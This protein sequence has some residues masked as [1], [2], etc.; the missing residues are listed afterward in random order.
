MNLTPD[1]VKSG[2]LYTFPNQ[3]DVVIIEFSRTAMKILSRTNFASLLDADIEKEVS[4]SSYVYQYPV[5][6][7]RLAVVKGK[8]SK[9]ESKIIKYWAQT[10]VGGSGSPVLNENL[11]VIGIHCGTLTDEVFKNDKVQCKGIKQAIRIDEILKA[12]KDKLLDEYKGETM[13]IKENLLRRT[14]YLEWFEHSPKHLLGRSGNV[15]VYKIFIQDRTSMAAKIIERL[16]NYESQ[17]DVLSKK[18]ELVKALPGHL[19]Q[20]LLHHLVTDKQNARVLIFTE[21]FEGG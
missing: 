10:E 3:L 21:Y 15:E 4:V 1:W 8:I 11:K 18:F 20:P 9:I 7:G 13:I 5:L 14:E 16:D 6:N 19:R 2:R 12:F 17:V